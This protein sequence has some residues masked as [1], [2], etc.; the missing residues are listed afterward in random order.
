[1]LFEESLFFLLLGL[2]LA[3]HFLKVCM[4]VRESCVHLSQRKMAIF[5][6]NLLWA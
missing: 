5:V 2:D 4:I 3:I 6:G 1:M